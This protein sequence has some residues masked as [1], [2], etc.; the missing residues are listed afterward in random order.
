[1]TDPEKPTYL[2]DDLMR[3]HYSLTPAETEVANGLLTG[4]SLEE[5]AAL[6]RVTVG[7][8]RDQLKNLF[9]KTGTNRQADLVRLLLNLPHPPSRCE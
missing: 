4:Y 8:I 5:I 2:R 9:G 7:T 1:V 6:R 3:A